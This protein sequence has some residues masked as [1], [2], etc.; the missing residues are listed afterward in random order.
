MRQAVDHMEAAA[1]H[2]HAYAAY[3]LGVA[4]LFETSAHGRRLPGRADDARAPWPESQR[5]EAE[6][7]ESSAELAASWFARSGLPEGLHAVALHHR[8]RGRA[9]EASR[10]DDKARTLGFGTP[11]R[12]PAR[13]RTGSGGAGGVSL[14][15]AWPSVRRRCGTSTTTTRSGT[16]AAVLESNGRSSRRE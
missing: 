15:S 11:W 16:V 4:H 1:R 8:A 13:E 12:E 2:G 5:A 10:W 6:A 14:Y 3:N 7:L 9:A